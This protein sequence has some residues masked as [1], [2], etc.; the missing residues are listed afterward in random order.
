MH[1]SVAPKHYSQVWGMV[2][3]GSWLRTLWLSWD[4]NI[5]KITSMSLKFY[6]EIFFTFQYIYNRS[7][8]TLCLFLRP[9]SKGRSES[10]PSTTAWPITRMSWPSLKARWSWW[11]ARRT[12]SGGSVPQSFCFSDWSPKHSRIHSSERVLSAR[13]VAIAA[14]SKKSMSSL[15]PAW[16][17]STA[18]SFSDG[19]CFL[20]GRRAA[21]TGFP[22]GHSCTHDP[23]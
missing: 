21:A 8:P 1:N 13:S 4:K 6:T 18:S 20:C 22:H 11:T 12:R 5:R 15:R 9:R 7:D 19:C 14:H 2:V 23:I 10:K 3:V 17:A 16:P